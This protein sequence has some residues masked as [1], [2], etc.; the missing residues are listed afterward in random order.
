MFGKIANY[1]LDLDG[2]LVACD[3]CFETFDSALKI[4]LDGA[5]PD[6]SYTETLQRKLPVRLDVANDVVVEL[7]VPEIRVAFGAA[8]KL[9]AMLVPETAVDK[10]GHAVLEKE[11]VGGAG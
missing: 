6:S 10:N 3:K 5:F 7:V 8:R 2:F 1:F 11:N 9:A 4:A